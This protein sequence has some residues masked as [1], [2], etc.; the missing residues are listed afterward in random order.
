MENQT[1]QNKN[2]TYKFNP[3]PE[4]EARMNEILKLS[5]SDENNENYE[6]DKEEFW[7]I[8]HTEPINSI[9]VNT[10][11]ITPNELKKK[12][13]AR[14]WKIIQPFNN[15]NHPEI[16]IIENNLLQGELGRSKEHLL[17]YY[18]VQEISSMLPIIALSPSENDSFIDLCASP[19]SKTTQA[20]SLMKNQG[21]IIANDNKIG[22]LAILAS[23]LE[24]CGVSNTILTKRDGV[25]LCKKLKAMNFNVD[26][27]LVDAPCS[28]EGTLRSSPKT[29]LMWN[30]KMI[31]VFSKQ[32]K[33]LAYS[34]LDLLKE[35]GEMIYSTC[36]HSPEENEEVVQFLLDNFNIEIE[37]IKPLLPIKARPGLTNWKGKKFSK[38][39]NKCARIYPQDNNTEGFFVCKIKKLSNK[40]SEGEKDDI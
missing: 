11:K 5:N 7:R 30:E 22:R 15:K 26:K 1:Q 35:G 8:V 19:G 9:R 33:S 6:K 21:N 40:A 39:I 31:N 32:Q 16:L 34:A 28:G 3:K 2:K 4:F 23:N 37:E 10:L 13:E 17:G 20:A 25:Q 38:E 12:L 14:G 29:Y 27:I 18:Y 24:K 36:T